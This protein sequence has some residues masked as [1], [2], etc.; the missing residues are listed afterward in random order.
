MAKLTGGHSVLLVDDEADFLESMARALQR[1]G[2]EPICARNS[3][4]ALNILNRDT[5]DAAVLDV[6]MPGMQ[7]DEL[8]RFIQERWPELPVVL[9]TGHGSVEQAFR[10]SKQGVFAYLTKPCTVQELAGTLSA[11]LGAEPQSVTSQVVPE[12]S[13]RVLLVDD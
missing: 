6:K 3:G 10:T 12:T 7:G 11:A 2:F 9:L 8:F 13:I 5:V 4:E 1:R